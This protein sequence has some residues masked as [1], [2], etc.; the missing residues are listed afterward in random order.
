LVVQRT[1]LTNFGDLAFGG[2]PQVKA[3]DFKLTFPRKSF[4]SISLLDGVAL[5]LVT[6]LF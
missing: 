2:F 6:V 5:F 3:N 1:K 4:N